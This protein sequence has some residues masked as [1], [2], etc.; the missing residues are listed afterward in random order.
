MAAQRC[1]DCYYY[2]YDEALDAYV[3][4]MDID[5]DEL[6]HICTDPRHICPYFRPGDE[7][8]LAR[9]Q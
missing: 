8:T 6:Y 3:C 9:R 7:Y 4:Y 1:E 2:D 5:E